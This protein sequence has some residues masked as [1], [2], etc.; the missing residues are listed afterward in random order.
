[1]QS[2]TRKI[3]QLIFTLMLLHAFTGSRAQLLEDSL[4]QV[5]AQRNI[6]LSQRL[7][8]MDRLGQ[9]VFF[10]TGWDEGLD[11]L[12]QSISLAA[13]MKDGQYRAHTY[14]MLAMSYNIMGDAPATQRYLDSAFWYVKRS[15]S[16]LMKGY[17]LYCKGWLQSRA[18]QEPQ[19]IQTF[20]QALDQ[21]EGVDGALKYQQSI[22]TELTGVYFHWYDLVNLEKYTKLSLQAANQTGRLSDLISANQVR[23]S[24][25]VNLYR[26]DNAQKQ[27]LDSGLFYM[28]HSLQ[29][30]MNNRE[31][32]VTPSD[33]PFAAISIANIFL[34]NFPSARPYTDSIDHYN[35]IALRESK[36]TKQ[37]VVEAGVYNTLSTMCFNKGDYDAAIN[38]ANGAIAVSAQ[39]PLFDKFNLSQSFLML[40]EAYEKKADTVLALHNYKQYMNLYKELF[41]AEKMN[42]SKEL[43]A[44]YEVA[45]KEKALLEIRLVAEQRNRE[46]IQA[47]W[48]S[49]QKDQALL[50]ARFAASEKDKALL[51]AKFETEQQQQALTMANYKTA[52]REQELN[53]MEET[54]QHNRRLQKIYSALAIALFL[55]AVFLYYAYKQ[56][57]KTLLQAKQLH[58][59]EVDKMKQEHR[60]SNLSAMLEGQEQERTRL[61]RDLHDGLGGLLSGVKIQLS[62]LTPMVKEA[63]QQAIVGKTLHHLDN[64]VDELRRIAKSMMPEVLLSYGLGE[65]AKEYCNGLQNSGIP[66]TCQVYKYKNDMDHARQVTMYRIMQELVNN[67]VKHAQASQILVQ[68]QQS[69]NRI[70]LTVEDDGKGFDIRKMDSLHGAGLANIRSRVEM[71]QGKMDLQSSEGAGSSFTIECSIK[72]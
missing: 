28:R 51:Q 66:V 49:T 32:L 4:R 53:A 1:M 19:A 39:D 9:V 45:K 16:K 35:D 26:N 71:L 63:P 25:F 44:R 61:A 17:V 2:G 6:P 27:A 34:E 23:G 72:H 68:L 58:E 24:Y 50:A 31:R 21:L 59:M 29:L 64:A 60:I 47:R 5:L 13:G 37:Y 11:I 70:F 10:N 54:M 12:R 41:D 22:Y 56:R 3:V 14:A 52:K 42:K 55:A 43:E 57:T 20:Q 62:G 15:N 48:L 69:G 36:L 46:L 65:A 38:Y 67:A 8:T 33:I 40:A 7:E 30:A 18:H